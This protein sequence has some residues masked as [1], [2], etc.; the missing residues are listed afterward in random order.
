[1]AFNVTTS[2]SR[3]TS[4]GVIIFDGA[5]SGA[6][7]GHPHANFAWGYGAISFTTPGINVSG[8]T[9]TWSESQSANKDV[10]VQFQ[11]SGDGGAQGA[12]K[13]GKVPADAAGLATP[14][15]DTPASN[16]CVV[17][18]LI[19]PNTVESFGTVTCFYRKSTDVAYTQ[20]GVLATLSGGSATYVAATLTGLS[21]STG[22]VY[23]FQILR[24]TVNLGT[25]TSP[26]GSFTTAAPAV[27]SAPTVLTGLASNVTPTTATLNGTVNP[28]G[29]ATTYYFQWGSTTAYGNTTTVAS[30]GS[31]SSVVAV[32]AAITGLATL[33]T[34]HY[35][36][37]ATNSGGT[38]YGAD[39]TFS[40]GLPSV[41]ANAVSLIT[42]N[43]TQLNGTINPNGTTC[44]VHFEY[45]A[46]SGNFSNLV[47][48]QAGLTGSSDIQ[49]PLNLIGLT[50]DTAYSYRF[51]AVE[52]ASQ[53]SVV[54][55]VVPWLTSAPS[56]T[57]T[58][59]A[60]TSVTRVSAQLN[61][62]VN[63]QNVTSAAF[64]YFNY[65]PVGG[66]VA[67]TTHM[68]VGPTTQDQVISLVLTGLNGGTTYQFQVV[69]VGPGGTTTGSTL[70]FTTLISDRTVLV[71]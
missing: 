19:N 29:G 46:G 66:V 71:L 28:N 27:V 64:W 4:P 1:M 3:G 41:I 69:A 60:A 17:H 30:A 34:Y 45:G 7:T 15:N 36:L 22:Y 2:G 23:Y 65:N 8:D 31:G 42:T 43:T 32:S 50:Q 57:V 68:S 24:N 51:V 12:T 9:G 21:S 48:F 70:T 11:A 25:G 55:N 47:G 14:F 6:G 54:S 40:P 56:P 20:T 16:S 10:T 61:A 35:Q 13:S 62:I 37:V 49:V 39:S 58:T 38:S 53:S 18:C 67:Q 33:T 59:Q 52:Q 63:P 5:W 44:T 26:T